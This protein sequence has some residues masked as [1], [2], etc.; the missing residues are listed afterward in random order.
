[1][2][3]RFDIAIVGAGPAGAMAA[4]ECARLGLKTALIEKDEINRSKPCGGGISLKALNL[5]GNK[6]P[7]Y[8]IEQYV[9]GFRL[10]SPSLDSVEL[11]SKDSIGISTTRDKFDAFLINKAIEQGCEFISSDEIIDISILSNKVIG[12]LKSGR[13][14]ES[15]IIIGADGANSITARKARLRTQWKKDQVGLCLVTTILL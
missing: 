4:K 15:H 13:L 1:L 14:I 5:I 2:G 3:E 7:K 11:I 6:I 8:L 12:R 9:K 10:F